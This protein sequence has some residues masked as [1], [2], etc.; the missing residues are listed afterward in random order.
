MSSGSDHQDQDAF[1]A[2]IQEVFSIFEAG[3][4]SVIKLESN[5]S[6]AWSPTIIT[7]QGIVHGRLDF[8]FEVDRRRGN[9]KPSKPCK[10]YDL[11]GF[12]FLR[13]S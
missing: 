10:S 5:I 12:M 7:L 9:Q 13:Q 4:K 1:P 2:S 6:P 8:G 11:Q 3:A